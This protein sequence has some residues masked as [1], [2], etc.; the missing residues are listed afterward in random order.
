MNAAGDFVGVTW[1]GGG[2]GDPD[3]VYARRVRADGTPQG[4][5]FQVNSYTTGSQRWSS[6]RD[7]PD[8]RVHHGAG[9]PNTRARG[10]IQGQRF[11]ADGVKIDEFV[12]NVYTTGDQTQPWAAMDESGNFVVVWQS[13]DASYSSNVIARR[14]DASGARLGTSSWSIAPPPGGRR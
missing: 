2:P 13:T 7:Q 4:P 5:A 12:V 3:G 6:G 11:D 14:F 8:R 1:S 9:R 10:E